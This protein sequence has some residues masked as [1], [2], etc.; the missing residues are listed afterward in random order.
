MAQKN[1][2]RNSNPDSFVR[3]GKQIM[4]TDC[5]VT[6]SRKFRSFFG[7]SPL[8]CSIA[9]NKISEDDDFPEQSKPYHFLWALMFLKI[10]STESILAGIAGCTEKTFRKWSWKMLDLLQRLELDLV[11]SLCKMM[12]YDIN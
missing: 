9:F 4:K 8:V 12:F 10:Y 2:A 6:L 1:K 5:N 7:V 11:C 3:Y